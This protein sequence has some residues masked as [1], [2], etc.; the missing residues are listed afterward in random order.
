MISNKSYIYKENNCVI[1]DCMNCIYFSVGKTKGKVITV[2]HAQPHR[3][4]EEIFWYIPTE[5][6]IKKFCGKGENF[7]SCPRFKAFQEHQKTIIVK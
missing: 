6:E 5:D 1:G 7:N 2:C 4:Q 3:P